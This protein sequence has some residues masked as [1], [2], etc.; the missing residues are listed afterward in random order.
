MEWVMITKLCWTELRDVIM[1]YVSSTSNFFNKPV[2][3][4]W[5]VVL[6]RKL[7]HILHICWVTT[8]TN[9]TTPTKRMIEVPSNENWCSPRKLSQNQMWP[10]CE[11]G[12]TCLLYCNENAGHFPRHSPIKSILKRSLTCIKLASILEN[13][14]LI[15]DGRRPD[16]MTLGPWFKSLSLLW[17]TTVVD[18]FA[19]CH[20]KDIARY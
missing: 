3:G 10:A 11:K 12:C 19:Q 6:N 1:S 9:V 8:P 18:T 5:L 7:H 4:I 13:V 15:G 20:C 17:D 2:A 16:G 14:S